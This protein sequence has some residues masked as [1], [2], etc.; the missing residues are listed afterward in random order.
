MGM[1][2]E[3]VR[4]V[5]M[6]RDM[7]QAMDMGLGQATNMDLDRATST[8]LGQAANTDTA[9]ATNMDL[10]RAI[11]TVPVPVLTAQAPTTVTETV[12]TAIPTR[13][14]NRAVESL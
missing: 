8:G 5:N 3:V 11:N 1:E 6:V 2:M 4:A 14:A 12:K 9:Q 13:T 7:D 10:V